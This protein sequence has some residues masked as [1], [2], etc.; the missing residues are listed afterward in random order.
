MALQVGRKS[1]ERD[2]VPV[3]AKSVITRANFAEHLPNFYP[4]T[5]RRRPQRKLAIA[6]QSP[7]DVAK[8][9]NAMKQFNGRDKIEKTKNTAIAAQSGA[10]KATLVALNQEAMNLLTT[11]AQNGD[12]PVKLAG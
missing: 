1:R 7:A 2:I 4:V 3:V 10:A 9:K 5:H 12:K 11:I 6:P 8:P